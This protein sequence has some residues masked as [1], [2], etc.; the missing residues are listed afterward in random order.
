MEALLEELQ[1]QGFTGYIV[2]AFPQSSGYVFVRGGQVLNAA[3]FSDRE[4]RVGKQVRE[5]LIHLAQQTKG[6]VSVYFLPD[7]IVTALSGVADWPSLDDVN[8]K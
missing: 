3:E 7:D 6:T 5:H 1:S 8:Q 4:R 2:M